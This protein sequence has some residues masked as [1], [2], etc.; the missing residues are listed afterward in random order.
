MDALTT[1]TDMDALKA[2]SIEAL[3]TKITHLMTALAQ[4]TLTPSIL[5]GGASL[6]LHGSSRITDDIDL[7]ISGDALNEFM[8]TKE[9]ILKG[10]GSLR[11]DSESL[12][13]HNYITKIDLLNAINE[14]FDFES[15]KSF[16]VDISGIK[17][18]DLDVLLG[19]KV[20]CYHQRSEGDEGDGKRDSDMFDIN[21]ISRELASRGQKVR[22]E[23]SE[24][25]VCGP[26]NMLLVVERLYEDYREQGV[27]VFELAG[28]REFE[29]DW[30]NE[31][32][33]EQVEYYEMEIEEYEE[34]S[35]TLSLLESQRKPKNL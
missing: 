25:M 18:P 23:V 16:T 13:K 11:V 31:E 33:L 28:G 30:G 12:D 27:E 20:L 2:D 9:K 21:W 4:Q 32:F 35:V 1:Q 15:I 3:K 29:C 5:I 6:L 24:K 8:A 7:L 34:N 10:L 26:Y 14:R 22:K 19:S 17:V